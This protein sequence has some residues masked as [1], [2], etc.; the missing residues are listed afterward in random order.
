M[1]GLAFTDVWAVG[2]EVHHANSRTQRLLLFVRAVVMKECP[3]RD[4]VVFTTRYHLG[5][6]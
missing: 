4:S 2:L 5:D 3:S 1:I 6:H